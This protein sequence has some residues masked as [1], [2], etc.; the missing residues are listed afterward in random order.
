MIKQR[1]SYWEHNKDKYKSI[2]DDIYAS[3][4]HAGRHK[5]REKLANSNWLI[6]DSNKREE[7]EKC[8]EDPCK[9]CEHYTLEYKKGCNLDP[10]Q[11]ERKQKQFLAQEIKLYF[12]LIK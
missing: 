1:E 6:I 8:L 10:Q 4:F 3:G 11:C 2:F 5:E 9:Y 7:F 12:D